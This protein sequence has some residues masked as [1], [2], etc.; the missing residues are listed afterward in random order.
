M[1]LTPR[2][3]IRP[4]CFTT[5]LVFLWYLNW[6]VKNENVSAILVRSVTVIGKRV[7]MAT[8]ILRYK[9]TKTRS[10]SCQV[11]SACAVIRLKRIRD[12]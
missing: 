3:V 12:N 5:V 6:G 4:W 8:I 9:Q 10:T 7:R 11:N 2:T 1:D